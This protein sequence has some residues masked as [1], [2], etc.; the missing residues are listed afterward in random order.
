MILQSDIEVKAVRP[1]RET[2]SDEGAPPV[3]V[4][5]LDHKIPEERGGW[6]QGEIFCQTSP[7]TV[8]DCLHSRARVLVY[9]TGS[10]K[11]IAAPVF[12]FQ[13]YLNIFHI[14]ISFSREDAKIF[15]QNFVLY[16]LLE[17]VPKK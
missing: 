4:H 8:G 9:G 12:K 15:V 16:K 17:I 2:D 11:L 14:F 13:L 7:R 10:K 1:I 6:K 5:Y 3:V